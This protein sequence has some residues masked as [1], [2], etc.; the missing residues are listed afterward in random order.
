[1]TTGHEMQPSSESNLSCESAGVSYKVSFMAGE[2]SRD[3]RHSGIIISS[4]IA[5]EAMLL[6]TT[7]RINDDGPGLPSWRIPCGCYASWHAWYAEEGMRLD[8]EHNYYVNANLPLPGQVE[9]LF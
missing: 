8:L 6:P 7:N 1:M 5:L 9:F 2:T 3:V 4:T